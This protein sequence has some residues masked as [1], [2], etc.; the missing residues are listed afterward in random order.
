MTNE[1]DWEVELHEAETN[2]QA[3][4]CCQK[5][6]DLGRQ[7]IAQKDLEIARLRGIFKKYG[8][9]HTKDCQSRLSFSA[10]AKPHGCDCGLKEDLESSG[11]EEK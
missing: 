9:P 8:K 10:S 1:I 2:G 3:N 11:A 4:D 7:L 6:I 5:Y